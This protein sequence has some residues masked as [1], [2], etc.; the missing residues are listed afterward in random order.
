MVY[1]G[2]CHITVVKPWFLHGSTMVRDEYHRYHRVPWYKFGSTMV[3]DGTCHLTMV[4]PWFFDGS[5][6]VR[7]E[8]HRYHGGTMVLPW[9]Y[10]G[11]HGT[12]L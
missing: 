10:H 5:T 7:D 4:K 2:T 6:M 12:F 3:Y 11:Y 8:Y 9:F 1:H